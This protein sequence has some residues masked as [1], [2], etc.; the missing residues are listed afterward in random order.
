MKESRQYALTALFLLLAVIGLISMYTAVLQSNFRKNTE[1]AAVAQNTRCADAIH[2]LVSNKFT[3]EDFET[4]TTAEDMA[5]PRYQELQ[6]EL[7]ELRTLNSTR[8][9]YTAGRAEDGTL[10]YLIDGLDLDAEDFAYPGTA[11]EAEMI[12]YIS[13][14][15]DGETIYSR[16]IVDTTWGHIFTA[17]YPVW[18]SGASPEIIGALCMEMDEETTYAFLAKNRLDALKAALVAG[19]VSVLLAVWMFIVLRT[20]RKKDLEQQAALQKAAVAADAANRAKSTFLS[21]MSHDIRTPMNAIVG[22]TKLMEHERDDPEKLELYI[23]KVQSS[24]RYLLSLIN[25]VLDMSKIESG[26]VTLNH[27]PISL[28]EQ[29]GQIDSIIRP[30]TEERGQ[31][32]RVCVHEIVH[33]SLLGDA[34]RLRQIFINLLSNAVKYT[35]YGGA[36]RLDL[37]E[38]PG[39]DADHAILG[40]TVTDTGY[41]MTPE[42]VAHIFEPFTR[43]ENSITNRVQGTGLGMAITKNIVDLMGGTIRVESEPGKGSCFHVTLPLQIDKVSEY[44]IHA[45]GV[46]LVTADAALIRNA[47]AAFRESGVPLYSAETLEQAEV[48]VRKGTVDTVLLSGFLRNPQLPTAVQRLRRQARGGLLVFCLDYAQ[49]DQAAE[50]LARSGVNGLIVRPIFLSSFACAVNQ[51]RSGAVREIA[52]DGAVLRGKR[53]LCAEDNAL[54][55]E[56]LN[57]ILDTNGACCTIYP[58]GKKLAEAFETVQPGEYDAILMDVQMPVMNGLDATRAIRR[59]S[60]PLGRTI[61]IIAMTANAFSSDVQECLDAGM[62][63]HVSKPLDVAVLERTLRSLLSENVAGGGDTCPP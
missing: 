14:A 6:Q 53:F 46:L 62:D 59:S 5:L 12:P 22:I 15:L 45:A 42:F 19:L 37:A 44:E 1:E 10:I 39:G 54:N 29:V 32:F 31:S 8:Y 49:R 3:R 43:A 26:E 25:D 9:L 48:V 2:R 55:A 36:I 47:G 28:A 16:E 7:N 30:Q 21:N 34:V 33:E 60:N 20:Q 38:L 51:A 13:A 11:I 56:I 23:H 58:N 52:E 35:P 57:A 24:S 18:S 61:P 63:A 4:I 40:I 17:C 41:G 50:V 27:E